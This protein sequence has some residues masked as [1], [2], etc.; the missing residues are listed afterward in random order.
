MISKPY[1]ILLPLLLAALPLGVLRAGDQPDTSLLTRARALFKPLPKDFATPDAPVTPARVALGRMLFFDPRMSLESTVSCSRCHQPSLYGT[2]GLPLSRGTQD[3]LNSRNAPT[4]LNAAL[5]APVHWRG[6]RK[7][8]ED[9]ATQ[10]LVG[11]QSHALPDPAAAVARLKGIP[12][13]APMFAAAFPNEGDP[14]TTVNWGKAIGAYERTLVTP[15]AF[16]EFLQGNARALSATQKRGLEKFM[17]TGC[18]GCHNGV[19][20]GGA[21]FFKFGLVEDYWKATGSKQIDKGRFDVT[22]EPS[23]TYVFKVPT[24]RNVAMTAPYFHD[25]SI[26]SLPQAVTIMARV[27]LGRTL[28]TDDASDIVAFLQS[29][30]GKLPETFATAPVLPITAPEVVNSPPPQS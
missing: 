25:G 29:L 9:Q 19:G 12:G 24:L 16:D 17:A 11:A 28:S 5:Q 3:R 8:V 21:G 30:T 27:Q 18:T 4:V 20:V 7:N 13:Y 1:A 14:I 6:D 15:S 10:A 22:H 23:D 26:S 2:D